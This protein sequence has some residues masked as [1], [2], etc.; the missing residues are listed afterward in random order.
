M[1]EIRIRNYRSGDEAGIIDV[2]L[3]IQRQE[4][5]LPI[6][7][8]DQPDL[9]SISDFYVQG[10]GNFWVAEAG[11]AIVGTIALKDIGNR[12]A[13]LR[14]MFV[15]KAYRG[16]TGVAQLLLE[17]LLADAKAAGVVEIFLGTTA[18]FL[19]AHRFYEKNGFGEIAKSDLPA[20]FPLMTV[21]SKFYRLNLLNGREFPVA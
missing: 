9:Q 14:K 5:G 1:T 21:D 10:K 16:Q 13:A 3:P 19:A 17:R 2:I 6:T 20:S 12:L 18:A 11:G 8:E 7:A 15:A 4:F